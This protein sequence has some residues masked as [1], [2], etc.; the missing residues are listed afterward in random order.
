MSIATR[1]AGR[2]RA[3]ARTGRWALLA[4]CLGYFMTILDTTVV[5]VALPDMQRRLGADIV[6]LQWIVDGYALAFASLLLT[7]GALGD[8]LGNKRVFVGGVTL[9]TLAS[10]GC[11]L[12][13]DLTALQVMRIVQGAGAALAVP[14]S[15]ALLR[16]VSADPSERARA[17]G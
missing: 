16:H 5:N 4:I 2:R 8:R 17:F 13:P 7:A 10:A 1:T 6:D 9:F 14:A 3:E 12:A 11:G 15:L